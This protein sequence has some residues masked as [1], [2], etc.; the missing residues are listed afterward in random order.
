MGSPAISRPIR[1]FGFGLRKRIL[2]IKP[3]NLAFGLHEPNTERPNAPKGRN[4]HDEAQGIHGY[5]VKP[6]GISGVNG[7]SRQQHDAHGDQRQ[8]GQYR[9]VGPRKPSIISGACN[10]LGLRAHVRTHQ[11]QKGCGKAKGHVPDK[12]RGADAHHPCGI[13]ETVDGMVKVIS[14]SSNLSLRT[15]KRAIEAVKQHGQGDGKSAT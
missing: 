3:L 1:V 7:P 14:L 9:P 10:G 8:E 12:H 5:V 4:E 11:R 15:C 2:G 6:A 13:Q